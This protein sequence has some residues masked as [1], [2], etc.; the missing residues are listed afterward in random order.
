MVVKPA[1]LHFAREA[2]CPNFQPRAHAGLTGLTRVM[3]EF[4][5]GTSS[6]F[7]GWVRVMVEFGTS[8]TF[9]GWVRVMVSGYDFGVSGKKVKSR[10]CALAS[11]VVRATSIALRAPRGSLARTV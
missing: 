5:F 8:F 3:V 7:R 4:T 9:R 11:D 1:R 6:T 2:S 10:D